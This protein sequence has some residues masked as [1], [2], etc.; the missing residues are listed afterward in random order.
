MC[1]E[2]NSNIALFKEDWNTY[3]DFLIKISFDELQ[4]HKIYTYAYNIRN[5]YFEV[6]YDKGFVKEAE[7]KDHVFINGKLKD[8]LI[9]SK[10]NCLK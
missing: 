3:L 9:L 7:L 5:Y 1:N 4:F 6:M 2:H 8:V 10:F